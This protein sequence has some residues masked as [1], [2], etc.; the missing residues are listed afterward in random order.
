MTIAAL[1]EAYE[2][3]GALTGTFNLPPGQKSITSMKKAI[4]LTTDEDS[5]RL[6]VDLV[7]LL[8]RIA[9]ALPTTNENF[10]IGATQLHLDNINENLGHINGFLASIKEH[11]DG[12]SD[13][14]IDDDNFINLMAHM[15]ASQKRLSYI[16]DYLT[17]VLQIQKTSIEPE[18]EF[19]AQELIAFLNAA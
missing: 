12:D 5:V 3:M 14:E 18:Q 6:S 4:C 19:T 9:S 1:N 17:L 16:S 10:N 7:S 15:Q 13:I 8:D 11:F 2:S